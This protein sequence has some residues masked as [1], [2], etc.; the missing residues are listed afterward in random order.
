MKWRL[1][2]SYITK[3]PSLVFKVRR[4]RIYNICFVIIIDSKF[5]HA[6]KFLHYTYVK[7]QVEFFELTFAEK[8]ETN[9]RP[10]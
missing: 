10:N 5:V 8:A 1:F 6:S 3:T 9:S 2:F 7:N 4:I